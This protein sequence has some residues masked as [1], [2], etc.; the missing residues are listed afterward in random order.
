MLKSA[1]NANRL[2]NFGS[3]GV[4]G[5]YATFSYVGV[6]I[7]YVNWRAWFSRE[8]MA[9]ATATVSAREVNR[10]PRFLPISERRQLGDAYAT[11]ESLTTM[12]IS[13][14]WPTHAFWAELENPFQQITAYGS[15]WFPGRMRGGA[16]WMRGGQYLRSPQ[17]LIPLRPIALP[18]VLNTVFWGTCFWILRFGLLRARR[19]VRR[20]HGRCLGC[21]YDL[22]GSPG[23][24][25]ECGQD[26]AFSAAPSG[27]SRAM[28]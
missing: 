28:S 12:H 1:W 24:C 10:L 21:G 23:T 3:N 16:P 13:A 19:A 27:E 8:E 2:G 6:D 7:T 14:G 9:Q 15:L 4:T 25:P 20:R 22:T 17:H 18:T 11:F 5:V 26:V